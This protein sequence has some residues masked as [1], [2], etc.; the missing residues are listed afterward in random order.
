M[1]ED[2]DW[3]VLIC[4]AI[5]CE[6]SD[7]H[8]TVGQR[9]HIRRDGVLAPVGDSPLSEQFI[10]GFCSVILSE[11]QQERLER[12]RNVDLSWTY[13][14]RRFRVNAYYQQGWPALALRL[15]PDR[16]PTLAELGAP[17]AWQQIKELEQGLVLV[18]GRTGS[19]KSTTLAAFI[20]ELNREKPYHI[21]TLEDPIEY[22]FTPKKAF[23]S[24]RELGRDFLSFPQALKSALRETPDVIMVGEI[25][26]AETLQ[27][28]MAAASTGIL[29]LG[30]LHTQSAE[31]TALRVEG[32]F[33]LGEQSQVRA[34][35]AEVMTGVFAQRLLPKVGGGRVNM[36]EVLLMVPAVRNLIRQGKY[37]QL[38]SVMLSHGSQG[39]Q[40]ADAVLENL[41]RSGKISQETLAH[42]HS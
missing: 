1:C 37:A 26:D 24:Q 21:V 7:V 4:M 34:R 32:L 5:E 10:T 14:G 20:E 27:T 36:T 42:Y 8:L 9:P 19:G 6:A 40:T 38:A 29:V 2:A 12:E 22:V 18:C 28:A 39:M 11:L 13:E 33:S 25:R 23:F 41:H 16:I 30:T 3:Q 15:L 31:E 35:F 17:A